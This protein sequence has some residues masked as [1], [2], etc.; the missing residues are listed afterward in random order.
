MSRAPVQ[1]LRTAYSIG[2][3]VRIDA[4]SLCTGSLWSI[5]IGVKI[6]ARKNY[7]QSSIPATIMNLEL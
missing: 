5:K 6:I 4:V 1:A 2:T 3:T 7:N